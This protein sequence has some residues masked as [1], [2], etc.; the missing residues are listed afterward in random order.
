MSSSPDSP[1]LRWSWLLAVASA[2]PLRPATRR[3]RRAGGNWPQ[4][5][6]PQARRH[7][8]RNGSADI[9]PEAGP[10]SRL[11][12]DGLGAGFSSV[13]V[14][15]G[16]IFT[17]GDRRDGQYVI[18]LDEDTGKELWA[19]RVGGRHR[20][21]VRRTARHADGGRRPALCRRYRWR[22]GL[23][24]IGHREG[25]LA[26]QHAARL[27]RPHDVAAGCSPSRRSSMATASS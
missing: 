22:R 8:D 25:A 11:D 18:A 23:P 1:V 9:W 15:G 10:P 26:P 24:R 4:W 27:R 13:A 14:V 7:L 20:R 3:H 12:R 21:R 5:R 17:M 19:T 16:R 6:G 2:S